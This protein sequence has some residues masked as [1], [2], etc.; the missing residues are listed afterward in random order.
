MAP[1]G[2]LDFRLD[3]P[4]ES[5]IVLRWV[6]E[7]D[8]GSHRHGQEG[9]GA[10]RP[11]AQ[12]RRKSGARADQIQLRERPV[13]HMRVQ[14]ER[15][16]RPDLYGHRAR[17]WPRESREEALVRETRRDLALSPAR[18]ED[19]RPRRA[20]GGGPL[21]VASVTP[22]DGS[23]SPLAHLYTCCSRRCLSRSA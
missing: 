9:R 17:F 12:G 21:P 19:R 14:G 3:P 11:E 8:R 18:G 4:G 10:P 16:C 6:E 22:R 15:S 1:C 5:R 20:V 13:R 2:V 23:T 7:E